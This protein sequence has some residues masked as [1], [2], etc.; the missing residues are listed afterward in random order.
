MASASDKKSVLVRGIE[1]S[2]LS[3][4]LEKQRTNVIVCNTVG[5]L[6]LKDGQ[7][8]KA[9]LDAGGK[10]LQEEC[11]KKYPNG[12]HPGEIAE[13]DRGK[14]HCSTVY[15]INIPM[16]KIGDV[17]LQEEEIQS[18]TKKC[19]EKASSDRRNTV[20][21]PALGTG[22]TRYNEDL[23]AK[24]MFK[25]IEDFDRKNPSS[26]VKS[27]VIVV[28]PSLREIFKTFVSE[29]KIRAG[30][31][32]R[33]GGAA[34]GGQGNGGATR[35]QNNNVPLSIATHQGKLEDWKADALVCSC[36][37]D[38]DLSKGG[39]AKSIL[40]AAGKRLQDEFRKQNPYGIS[41]GEV[42]IV[43]GAGL[44]NCKTVF[45]GCLYP[46]SAPGAEQC[47]SDFIIKCLEKGSSLRLRSVA[48]PC[49]GIGPLGFH[50]TQSAKIFKK[51]VDKFLEKNPHSSLGRIDVVVY[52]GASNWKDVLQTFTEELSK[53][54]SDK[55]F[56]LKSGKPDRPTFATLPRIGLSDL[57]F[58]THDEIG[59]G[60]FGVVYHGK[61]MGTDVAI[62][63]ITLRLNSAE[64]IKMAEQ[65]V[66]VHSRLR[67][68][69]IVQ[70]MGVCSDQT[71]FYIISEFI[72]GS[73]LHNLIFKPGGSGL[74]IKYKFAFAKQCCQAVA[75]LHGVEPPIIHQDIKPSNVLVS[76]V[77][78]Q[79][80]ICDFG[81][82]KIRSYSPGITTEGT[83][84]FMAPELLIKAGSSSFKSDI[85]A[86]GC[87]FLELFT[88]LD[89][90]APNKH[91]VNE[92]DIMRLMIKKEKPPA[93]P[94][95][96]S[97]LPSSVRKAIT[98]CFEYN[99]AKRPSALDLVHEF[100]KHA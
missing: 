2:V 90:W 60:G 36:S 27:V 92:E 14:L 94:Y 17:S 30:E 80:K 76:E 67:H 91:M 18:I 10:S 65:E 62:K 69:H 66:S 8:S 46:C 68:P 83:P 15:F 1:V 26:S 4:E 71:S 9:L 5:S 58:S 70:I 45:F 56:V 37:R 32:G 75:Y 54:G 52:G 97:R 79:A 44:I 77:T 50:P 88:G 51:S 63:K 89:L 28:H 35:G 85:W 25:A 96:D 86:L 59:R 22:K 24:T 6:A 49:L 61:W 64:V 84:Y 82:S 93:L 40:N 100:D 38:M 19:L 95:L 12:I 48:F 16:A 98:D 42:A 29:A 72:D 3:G 34:G 33:K 73:D 47:M 39:L 78:N 41:L 31:H 55:E 43:D 81:I 99:P 7:V 57:Q 87:T 23:V 20:A 13:V 11:S 53:K 21:F 74:K